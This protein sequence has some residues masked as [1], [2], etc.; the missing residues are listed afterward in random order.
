[1]LPNARKNIS[2]FHVDL[3]SGSWNLTY[4]VSCVR[5]QSQLGPQHF[6]ATSLR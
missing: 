2:E 1:M 3:V 6:D 5:N 4:A